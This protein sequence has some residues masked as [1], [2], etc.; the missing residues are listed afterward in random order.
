MTIFGS[1]KEKGN[2]VDTKFS[3][4]KKG[5]HSID[6]NHVLIKIPL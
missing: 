3:Q 1:L 4:T 6:S 2:H 5:T